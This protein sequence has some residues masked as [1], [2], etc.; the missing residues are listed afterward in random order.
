MKNN[1]IYPARVTKEKDSVLLEF[2]DLEGVV[3]DGDT[4]DQAIISAQ[5]VLALYIIDTLDQGKKLPEPTQVEEGAVYVH[6]W[7]PYYR[8]MTK[9]IYIKKTVTIPQWLDLLAK[10]NSINF[11]ACMVKGIKEELGID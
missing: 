11:S 8:N 1:Y 7:L 6:V 4:I 10:E 9:E 5:E 2:I 3:A